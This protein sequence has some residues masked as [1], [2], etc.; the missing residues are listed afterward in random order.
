MSRNPIKQ[1]S[2]QIFGIS[3]GFLK[4]AIWF[5]VV[6]LIGMSL[7]RF[8][9]R[10]FY[11][12]ALSNVKT[13]SVEF[14]IHDGENAESV[15]NRLYDLNLIDDKLAFKFR[16]K[17]Y[18]KKMNPNTYALDKSMTIKNMLDVFDEENHE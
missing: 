6:Y 18:K 3:I 10:L 2:I 1:F 5:L 12:R 17:I 14:T 4:L 9:T 15:A 11:E 16:A 8:G 7:F 13:E